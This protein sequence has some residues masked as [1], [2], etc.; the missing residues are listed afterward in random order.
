MNKCKCKDGWVVKDEFA[1]II[2][3]D[4]DD[5]E[6]DAECNT[7]GCGAKTRLKFDVINVEEIK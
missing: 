6:S 2:D 5:I 1:L 4:N 3:G 7:I